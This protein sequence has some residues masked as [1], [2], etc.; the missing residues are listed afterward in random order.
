MNLAISRN[1]CNSKRTEAVSEMRK[2]SKVI[3][4]QMFSSIEGSLPGLTLGM[5]DAQFEMVRLMSS[6]MSNV[7]THLRTRRGDAAPLCYNT[8]SSR[9]P[10]VREAMFWLLPPEAP[11][12]ALEAP[13]ALAEVSSS[14][15]VNLT[16]LKPLVLLD[17]FAIAEETGGSRGEIDYDTKRL[18]TQNLKSVLRRRPVTNN[19]IIIER[20]HLSNINNPISH[21]RT[22]D[23]HKKSKD[24]QLSLA[25]LAA[26]LALVGT[27]M[28]DPPNT[29]LPAANTIA[30]TSLNE[31]EHKGGRGGGGDG[32]GGAGS[33]GSHGNE[34]PVLRNNNALMGLALLCAAAVLFGGE[35]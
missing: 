35:L 8:S 17:L 19:V 18:I 2:P 31:T 5:L 9:P 32:D 20:N 10:D 3:A 7:L 23:K 29:A 4:A 33:G 24:M 6:Q 14:R 30:V 25:F 26:G 21:I 27:S 22:T 1:E 28:A 34:G 12:E 13:E 15:S 11:A 16:L